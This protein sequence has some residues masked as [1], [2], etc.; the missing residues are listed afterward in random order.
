MQL[1]N[2]ITTQSMG[3]GAGFLRG[4]PAQMASI[5]KYTPEAQSALSFL[6]G[7][8]RQ[9]MQDPYAGFE[10]IAQR[11][12]SQFNQQTVPGLAERFTSM[13][14]NALSSGAFASQIG[15]AGAGLEEGLAALQSQYGMQNRQM[16]LQ[17][18]LGGIQPQF[19][20]MYQP[21]EQSGF[22]A[23]LPHILQLIGKLGGAA[24]GRLG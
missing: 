5:N 6:L 18:L 20:N 1:P 13:G 24:M 17:E 8:G 12:R 3:K 22:E 4:R 11:A 9:N 21:R 16:S 23:L 10:P 2:Q 19:E 7:Q 15:Q 14:D